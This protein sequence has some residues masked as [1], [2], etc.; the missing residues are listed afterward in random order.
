MRVLLTGGAG[1]IGSHLA[2]LLLGQG[3]AVW[4]YDNLA[5]G[6]RSNVPRGA[7]LRFGDLCDLNAFRRVCA[8]EKPDVVVHLAAQA[9]VRTSMA[10]PAGD[11]R[12]NLSGGM[13]VLVAARAG[14]F[15][16]LVFASSGGAIYGVQT[17]LPCKESAV[18]RPLSPY[19]VAKL[20]F[21]R[22]ADCL[23]ENRFELINLRLGNVYGPFQNPE[24]EAGVVAIFAQKMLSGNPPI[25]F[26]NGRQTRDYVYVEDVVR[27]FALA[28]RGPEGTYNIGT[29]QETSIL[30]LY[31]RLTKLTA[32]R[33][34]P[35]WLPRMAGEVTRNA[36]DCR[37][38][39]LRLGWRAEVSLDAGLA[40]AVDRCKLNP[41]AVRV[42]GA[43][44]EGAGLALA[45]GARA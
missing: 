42:R 5:T 12:T 26:G 10:D 6:K 40:L 35:R 11:L 4:L 7:T 41:L 27:A 14:L 16:R 20:A 15:G 45:L 29:G 9:N 13:N 2:R 43:R 23:K 18:P 22:Y 25:I 1:F 19:G 28:L 44:R 37:L 36:L 8:R 24:G 38:A 34:E 32:F 21:E 33:G 31:E 30:R 17:E 3:H 39:R